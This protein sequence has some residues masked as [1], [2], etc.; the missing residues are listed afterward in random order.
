MAA[1]SA[2]VQA[3]RELDLDKLHSEIETQ[4]QSSPYPRSVSSCSCLQTT[5]PST[6][7]T[8]IDSN[9]SPAPVTRASLMRSAAAYTCPSNIYYRSRHSLI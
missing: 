5:L 4:Q 3:I 6:A 1:G 2:P 9:C 7:I 8:R